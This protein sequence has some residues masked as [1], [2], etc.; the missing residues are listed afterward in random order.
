MP[1]KGSVLSRRDFLKGGA[2][3]AGVFVAEYLY[4]QSPL[5]Q[6]VRPSFFRRHYI[7]APRSLPHELKLG[8]SFSGP[9]QMEMRRSLGLPHE[10]KDVQSD[11]VE[12]RGMGFDIFRHSSRLDIDPK[13]N[14]EYLKFQLDE[15]KDAEN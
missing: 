7:P 6:M 12:I 2:I 10:V 11:F 1:E 14:L 13:L 4:R 9:A 3:V 8:A 15:A 5:P